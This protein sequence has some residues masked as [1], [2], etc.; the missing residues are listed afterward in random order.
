MCVYVCIY[1]GKKVGRKG[2][3]EGW[4]EGRREEELTSINNHRPGIAILGTII[5]KSYNSQ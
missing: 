1:K 5:Q 3:R 4:R 2:E